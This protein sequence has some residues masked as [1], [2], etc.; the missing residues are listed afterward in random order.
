MRQLLNT[1]RGCLAGILL[2]TAVACSGRVGATGSGSDGLADPGAG[3]EAL[4]SYRSTLH[5]SF[6]GN[7]ESQ[8]LSWERTYALSVSREPAMRVLELD[9]A[10]GASADAPAGL[11]IGVIDGVEYRRASSEAECLASEIPAGES[12]PAIVEPAALLPSL[13]RAQAAPDPGTVAGV[14][15]THLQFDEGALDMPGVETA[16][17]EAW[18]AVSGG[19]VLQYSLEVSGGEDLFGEG[20]AGTLSW[21]YTLRD[22]DV[23]TDVRPPAGCPAGMVEAPLPPDAA[24]VLRQPGVLTF[25]TSSDLAGA[26]DFYQDQLPQSGWAA[27]GEPVVGDTLGVAEFERGQS[28]LTLYVFTEETTS[29]LLLLSYPG[30]AAASEATPAAPPVEPT[31]RA[32]GS[33][34]LLLGFGEA[35]F[36]LASFHLAADMQAPSW[37]ASTN[38]VSRTDTTV[39]ADVVGAD[40][41]LT[42][43]SSVDG[44]PVQ[45]LDGILDDGQEVPDVQGQLLL[46]WA[47][48]AL[49]PGLALATASTG[50]S[51]ERTDQLEGRVVEVYTLDTDQAV[52]QALE[53][54]RSFTGISRAQGTAWVDQETGALLRLTLDYETEF[55]EPAGGDLLGTGT[56]RVEI[57]VSRIGS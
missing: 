27:V 28:T 20:I 16:S 44:G 31:A 32:G 52:P 41:H 7:Q 39:S 8:P 2:L 35:G 47:S 19:Y 29:V 24:R 49:E 23:L 56:G 11:L 55:R 10:G 36:P 17:G 13:S 6:Q 38:S 40:V 26:V 42:V 25:A 48:W 33:L 18:I 34:N 21:E 14:S 22:P 5:I 4:S 54:V 43:A 1:A 51:L 53:A 30:P 3:L 15:A 12:Q 45:T 50:A 57:E 9:S 37:N 46:A